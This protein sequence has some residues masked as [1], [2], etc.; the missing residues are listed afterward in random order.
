M[1]ATSIL[2]AVVL[3]ACALVLLPA[4][5]A[6]DQA[7]ANHTPWS[8][9]WWSLKEGELFRGYRP[10]EPAPMQKY[11]QYA[12]QGNQ[13]T[14]WEGSN[15]YL[16]GG[17]GWEGHCHAWA[18]AAIM[19]EEPGT[20]QAGGI[21]FNIGDNKGLI[22]ECHYQ[23]QASFHG[24]RC[25]AVGDAAYADLTP[26]QLIDVLHMYIR[27]QGVPVVMDLEAGPQVWNY[28]VYQY[29]ISGNQIAIWAAD[30]GVDYD[31]T[32]T[33]PLQKVY[34][35]SGNSWVGQSVQDHPDFAWFPT[36]AVG[37]NPHVDIAKVREI[38]KLNDP[39]P[40]GGDSPGG[41][42][43]PPP[44]GGGDQPPP[45]PP[46]PPPGGSDVPGGPG[47]QQ[48]WQQYVN[49]FPPHVR[50]ALELRNRPSDFYVNVWTNRGDGGTYYYGEDLTIFFQADRDCFVT[51]L[52]I[53]STGK[54]TRLFPNAQSRSNRIQAGRVYRF[55]GPGSTFRYE[56]VPPAGIEVIKAIATTRPL[57]PGIVTKGKQ[58]PGQFEPGKPFQQW[59]QLPGKIF[60]TPPKIKRGKG[61]AIKDQLQRLGKRAWAED[62][63]VFFV[64]GRKGKVGQ[65]KPPV[66]P[67]KPPVIKPPK[68]PPPTFKP[69][70]KPPFIQGQQVV[71]VKPPIKPPVKKPRFKKPPVKRPPVKPVK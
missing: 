51:L 57:I 20:S 25:N 48:G 10:G 23:D 65:V 66:K 13:A 12:G 21:Q 7:S 58:R 34:T 64:E 46:P 36:V 63:C 43:P 40:G 30:D 54:V 17:Q 55:P 49:Q 11:D 67:I 70:A 3:A 8:G 2:M 39:G 47:G 62:L 69:P 60:K 68:P 53:D 6:Q 37:G 5:F 29:Q 42:Q 52:D 28:P 33:Q 24:T 71:P 16:P 4:A 22:T 27:D 50:E 45:P 9:Y 19:E 14:S 15:H 44:P 61:V 31:F 38:A 32:G 59:Q 56:I 18:A 1:R 41:D 35:F 26:Q